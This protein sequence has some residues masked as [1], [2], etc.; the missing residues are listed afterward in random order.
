MTEEA[1]SCQGAESSHSLG[2]SF[3]KAK[4]KWRPGFPWPG[5]VKRGLMMAVGHGCGLLG[6]R[7][8]PAHGRQRE[9]LPQE[10]ALGL[11]PS[12]PAAIAQEDVGTGMSG[13]DGAAWRWAWP[14]TL[15]TRR[16]PPSDPGLFLLPGSPSLSTQPIVRQCIGPPA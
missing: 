3:W 1:Q 15:A 6:P 8:E 16:A 9:A 5:T 12:P 14:G 7:G 10:A 2:S 11:R 4:A 13:S